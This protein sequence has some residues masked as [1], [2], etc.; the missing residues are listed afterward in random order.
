M[1]NTVFLKKEEKRS[2]GK[3]LERLPLTVWIQGLQAYQN[4]PFPSMAD[5]AYP[6]DRVPRLWNPIASPLTRLIVTQFLKIQVTR[7]IRSL[8]ESFRKYDKGLN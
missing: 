5:P 4:I 1:K 6:K 8:Q 3:D 2:G 7:T